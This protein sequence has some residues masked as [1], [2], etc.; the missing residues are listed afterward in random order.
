MARPWETPSVITEVEIASLLPCPI[1]A[2]KPHLNTDR[3]A[4]YVEHFAEAKPVAVFDLPEGLLLA[5]GHHR[6][7]AARRLGH[8][9]IQADVRRGTRKDAL[10]FVVHLAGQQ[11]GV[12]AQ[13]A[14]DAIRSRSG[15]AWG[16][17]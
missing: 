17:A 13:V 10:D 15:E 12:S 4:W 2:S 8:L 6:V 7:D 11:R 9:A 3:V 5:D 14:L 16:K 1:E